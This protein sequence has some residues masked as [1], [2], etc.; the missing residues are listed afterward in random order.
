[1]QVCTRNPKNHTEVWL[2]QHHA[3]PPQL[4]GVHQHL[5][6]RGRAPTTSLSPRRYRII[7]TDRT[8]NEGMIRYLI[9]AEFNLNQFCVIL[10][11]HCFIGVI[12]SSTLCSSGGDGP[13]HWEEENYRHEREYR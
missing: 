4:R 7:D 11:H 2:V 10:A 9:Q 12:S 3:V 5:E 8:V 1:M 6:H 13:Q